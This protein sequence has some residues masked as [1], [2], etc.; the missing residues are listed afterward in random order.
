MTEVSEEI[1]GTG[2]RTV[3]GAAVA[4]EQTTTGG[5][6]APSGAVLKASIAFLTAVWAGNYLAGKVALRY[7]PPLT[8]ATLRVTVAAVV[9]VALYPLVKRMPAFAGTAEPKRQTWGDL[10]T[11]A[12]LGLFGVSINQVCFTTGLRYTAISHSSII[13][14]MAPIYA[15]VLAVAFGLEKLS[16]RK[17]V[18]MLI[19]LAGVA[20]LASGATGTQRTAT[21]M[22]DLITLTGSLGFAMYGVL[23]KRVAGR[24]D[25]LTM[26][27]YNFAFGALLVLPLTVWQ[28]VKLG[29]WENWQRVPWQGWAGLLFMAVF[30]S[31][32]AYLFYFWLLRFY[33]VTKLTAFSYLL[34]PTASLL[35]ILFLGERGSWMELAGAGLALG[36][37]WYLE[38]K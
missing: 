6:K 26:I 21:V 15:M 8:L 23:G 13:V 27:T 9:M 24:Y 29:S 38:R 17:V 35:G 33:E 1:A 11:F 16:W 12:Y 18:G 4:R 10:W 20:V 7:L 19:A 28:A 5:G 3:A 14:G 2:A 22:G 25:P 31:V 30:S 34:P 32:L 36:G 37:V